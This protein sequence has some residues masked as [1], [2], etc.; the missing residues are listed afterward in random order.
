MLQQNDSDARTV[1]GYGPMQSVCN[2][3]NGAIVRKIPKDTS[4]IIRQEGPPRQRIT[5]VFRLMLSQA[6]GSSARRSTMRQRQ[7]TALDRTWPSAPFRWADRCSSLQTSRHVRGVV[8]HHTCGVAYPAKTQN[9]HSQ[10]SSCAVRSTEPVA[11]IARG[12][13][14][15]MYFGMGESGNRAR[16]IFST[17]TF[18][19]NPCT[20]WMLSCDRRCTKEESLG[21]RQS[22]SNCPH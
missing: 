18:P 19:P 16:T 20:E 15:G 11:I 2:L 14:V 12:R 6:T 9:V 22:R 8:V 7:G 21:N 3:Q 17:S 5:A 4:C 13:R 1:Q 10:P